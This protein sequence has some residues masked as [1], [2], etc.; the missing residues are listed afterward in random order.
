LSKVNTRGE[1]GDVRIL[2]KIFRIPLGFCG[3]KKREKKD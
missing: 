1:E 2:R 3:E